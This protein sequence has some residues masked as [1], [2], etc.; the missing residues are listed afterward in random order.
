MNPK[1][2]KDIIFSDD[3]SDEDDLTELLLINHMMEHHQSS[4]RHTCSVVGRRIFNRSA[5]VNGHDLIYNDYFAPNSTY[6]DE[7]FRRRFRMNRSLFLYILEKVE[8]NN[9]YFM[10]LPNAAGKMGHSSLHKR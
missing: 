1:Q 8:N 6:P 5:H 9:S 3:D 7:Y 10:Q 4:E 2:L